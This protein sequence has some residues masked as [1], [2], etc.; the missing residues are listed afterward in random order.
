[1]QAEYE[2]DFLAENG[3][4]LAAFVPAD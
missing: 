3:D 4:E 2:R 1:V